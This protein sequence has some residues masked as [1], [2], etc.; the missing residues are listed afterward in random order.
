MQPSFL[1]SEE[2]LHEK[3]RQLSLGARDFG[4]KNALGNSYDDADENSLSSG[5]DDPTSESSD[6]VVDSDVPDDVR[7][8]VAHKEVDA[9]SSFQS[10]EDSLTTRSRPLS[11]I[12]SQFAEPTTGSYPHPFSITVTAPSLSS[13]DS[14]IESPVEDERDC[15]DD[16]GRKSFDFTREI[17]RLNQGGTRESFVEQLEAAFRVPDGLKSPTAH[18]YGSQDGSPTALQWDLR[19]AGS[20]V[21]TSHLALSQMLVLTV[22]FS[23]P[24]ENHLRDISTLTSDL[25]PCRTWMGQIL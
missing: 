17:N 14:D 25:G 19:D 1:S 18:D 11:E 12:S 5:R 7:V 16:T 24:C 8:A 4:M 3:L 6:D 13:H 2:S 20:N 23:R 22:H 21:S 9:V 10:L 15:G